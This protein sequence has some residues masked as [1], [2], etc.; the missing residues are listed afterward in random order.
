VSHNRR[1]P[2]IFDVFEVDVRTGEATLVAENP[3]NVVGWQTDHA[4]RVRMAVTSDGVNTSLLYR[5]GATGDFKTI[6]TTDF[7]TTVT[8]AFF[9]WVR[10]LFP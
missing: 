6:V 10:I 1:D 8:P 9:A 2:K 7:R 5:E 3:G 4:G